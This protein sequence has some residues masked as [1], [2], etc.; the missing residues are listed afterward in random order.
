V[1]ELYQN[2]NIHGGEWYPRYDDSY[3]YYLDKKAEHG[4]PWVS[5]VKEGTNRQPQNLIY[6][7]FRHL[8]ILSL[9]AT[10]YRISWNRVQDSG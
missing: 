7:P 4:G 2:L 8:G 9:A 1:G 3:E 5:I 6:P 10:V